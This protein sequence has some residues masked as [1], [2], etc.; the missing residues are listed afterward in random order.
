M[1]VRIMKTL[2]HLRMATV[3][4]YEQEGWMAYCKAESMASQKYTPVVCKGWAYIKMVV[5]GHFLS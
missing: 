2:L 1:Q 3:V 4:N 5:G